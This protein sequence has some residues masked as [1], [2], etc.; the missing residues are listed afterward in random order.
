VNRRKRLLASIA[1]IE[2]AASKAARKRR[3]K[4]WWT[5]ERRRVHAALTRLKMRRTAFKRL[6]EL[7]LRQAWAAGRELCDW[8]RRPADMPPSYGP[9]VREWLIA[10]ATGEA[11]LARWR[12]QKGVLK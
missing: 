4:E 6:F 7:R 11:E 3:A 8:P 9:G 10:Q 1:A 2:T 5:P 12:R